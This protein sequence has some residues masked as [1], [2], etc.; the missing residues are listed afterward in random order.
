MKGLP[1]FADP[2]NVMT[3]EEPP[4]EI[5]PSKTAHDYLKEV[6][7]DPRLPTALRMKAAIEALP[8]ERPKLAVT[9]MLDGQDIAALL[10]ERLKRIAQ[11]KPINGGSA[12]P[13]PN[14]ALPPQVPDRRFRR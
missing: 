5:D 1:S 11:A 9:A 7:Q 2:A 14:P 3:E 13:A 4:G 12:A 8:F 10:D 6:Y